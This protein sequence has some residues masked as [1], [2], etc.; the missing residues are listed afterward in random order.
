MLSLWYPTASADPPASSHHTH[1]LLSNQSGEGRKRRLPLT[2][3]PPFPLCHTLHFS[4]ARSFGFI[5]Q[6][7]SGSSTRDT[8]NSCAVA[9]FG[10]SFAMT[11]SRWLPVLASSYFRQ[12]VERVRTVWKYGKRPLCRWKSHSPPDGKGQAF[13]TGRQTA[14]PQRRPAWPFAHGPTAPTTAAAAKI[15][16]PDRKNHHFLVEWG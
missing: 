16:F 14:F 1:G 6:G 8:L 9:P 12:Q 10:S 3:Q 11:T 4:I 5:N 15:A 13:P 7:I 2:E